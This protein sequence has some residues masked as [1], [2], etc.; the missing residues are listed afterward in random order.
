MINIYTRTVEVP[1]SLLKGRFPFDDP[2]VREEL[3]RRLNDAPGVDIP[4][5]KLGLYPSFPV[6]L[7]ADDAVWDVIVGTLDWFADQVERAE[8][9]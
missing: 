6:T 7:L 3:R 4:P 1:F 8:N 2:A 5:S 9:D